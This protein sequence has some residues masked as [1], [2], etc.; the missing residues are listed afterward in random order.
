MQKK[1]GIIFLK[2]D[3]LYSH[4][5]ILLNIF[6]EL[7]DVIEDLERIRQG[8]SFAGTSEIYYDYVKYN[9]SFKSAL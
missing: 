9:H 5:E 8:K 6:F 2:K 1:N 4:Q 3:I 7:T